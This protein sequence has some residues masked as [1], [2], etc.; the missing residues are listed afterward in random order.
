MFSATVAT[1]SVYI[2]ATIAALEKRIITVVDITG[3]HLNADVC[4]GVTVHMRI[5]AILA[6]MNID[7]DPSHVQ[8]IRCEG[9]LDVRLDRALYGFEESAYQWG[10]HIKGNLLSAGFIQN[11]HEV[12]CY[13]K[14][15]YGVQITIVI[16]RAL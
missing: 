10:D 8:F 2:V 5:D 15:Y 6:Q 13:N 12:C 14:S 3:A 11:S 9:A 7:L 16:R 1:S 4:E